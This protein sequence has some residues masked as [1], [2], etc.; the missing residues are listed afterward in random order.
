ME[1]DLD[2]DHH[3]DQP[4]LLDVDDVC[5]WLSTSPSLDIVADEIRK[6]EIRVRDRQLALELLRQHVMTK[7]GVHH[8]QPFQWVS[9]VLGSSDYDP[10]PF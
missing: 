3:A 8:A 4:I 6:L 5:D 2:L 9:D 10:E 7:I 1:D